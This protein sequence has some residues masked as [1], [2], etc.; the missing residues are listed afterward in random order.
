MILFLFISAEWIL[1]EFNAAHSLPN[2]GPRIPAMNMWLMIMSR[3]RTHLNECLSSSDN[4]FSIHCPLFMNYSYYVWFWYIRTFDF[5]SMAALIVLSFPL[6]SSVG[7]I[8]EWH[9]ISMLL[10][11]EEFK[12]WKV[13]RLDTSISVVI[14]E[15]CLAIISIALDRTQFIVF[16]RPLSKCLDSYRFGAS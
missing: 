11:K 4:C 10:L 16:N 8:T 13:A 9:D 5:F 7:K 14:L 15:A 12:S 6:E 3:E 2:K 1:M